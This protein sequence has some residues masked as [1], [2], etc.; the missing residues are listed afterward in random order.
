MLRSYAHE[1]PPCSSVCH[2]CHLGAL[3]V[4]RGVAYC[5]GS[6]TAAADG[7]S[8]GALR[9]VRYVAIGLIA[10]LS[11]VWAAVGL[12]WLERGGAAAPGGPAVAAFQLV[13]QDGAAV[14]ER[15]MLGRPAVVFFGFT[16]C[17]DVCPT[18]LAS[19]SALLGR[20]GAD[21]GRL[22][23]F[24]VSV[25]PERDTPGEMKKYLSSFDPRIR[26]LTG[27]VEQITALGRPLG[28]YFAKAKSGDSYTM[29]HTA[30]VF[31]LDAEGRFRGTIAYGEDAGVAEEKVR[32]LL[33]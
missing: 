3:P 10:A 1:A 4:V 20:L 11:L 22:G 27:T 6:F 32:A 28:V 15:V 30:S 7:M 31:L 18:T 9:V 21:A 12:G 24:F 26:G 13:D 33:R 17:P 25:D 16:Y 19:M 14:T 2:L 5:R 8:I 23:V 29:D